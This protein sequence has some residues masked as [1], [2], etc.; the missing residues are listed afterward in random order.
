M[1]LAKRKITLKRSKMDSI[2]VNCQ[3][4]RARDWNATTQKAKPIRI[5]RKSF[6]EHTGMVENEKQTAPNSSKQFRLQSVSLFCTPHRDDGG[7]LVLAG[8]RTTKRK[9]GD[10]TGWAFVWSP[11]PAAHC[12]IVRD[13]WTARFLR[14]K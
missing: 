9:I 3:E 11:Q 13:D 5:Q 4:L 14:K 10:G 12:G 2:C 1:D 7:K 6:P 8:E